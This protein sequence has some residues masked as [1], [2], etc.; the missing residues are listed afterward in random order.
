MPI[1]AFK[2]IGITAG[3]QAPFLVRPLVNIVFGALNAAFLDSELKNHAKLVR[4]HL[5]LPVFHPFHC[6]NQV[7]NH[8]ST[9]EWFAGG[10][11][12]TRAD[13]MMCFACIFLQQ[14]NVAGPE[15]LAWLDRAQK[16]PAWIRVS[17]SLRASR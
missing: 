15:T 6:V 14:F 3:L 17:G 11:G 2:L 13:F 7:E 12:P 1:A 10:D 9:R 16:R 5:H 4:T 8:L